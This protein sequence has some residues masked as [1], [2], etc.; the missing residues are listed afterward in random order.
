MAKK[1]TTNNFISRIISAGSPEE[2]QAVKNEAVETYRG[3]IHT[4][5]S[6][7]PSCDIQF[8]VQALT[9]EMQTISDSAAESIG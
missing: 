6:S 8:I 7:A 4:A 5:I 2:M 3:M 9:D 1:A